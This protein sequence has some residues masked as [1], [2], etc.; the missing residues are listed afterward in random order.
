MAYFFNNLPQSFNIL[1]R[2]TFGNIYAPYMQNVTNSTLKSN[3]KNY[4]YE[5]FN[6]NKINNSTMLTSFSFPKFDYFLPKFDYSLPKYSIYQNNF[7]PIFNN[8]FSVT[9]S[10][11]S[12]SFGNIANKPLSSDLMSWHEIN[13]LSNK[14]SWLDIDKNELKK[15]RNARLKIWNENKKVEKPELNIQKNNTIVKKFNDHLSRFGLQYDDNTGAELANNIYQ[16]SMGNKSCGYCYAFVKMGLCETYKDIDYLPGES[17]IDFS[18][19]FAENKNVKKHFTKIPF[20]IL[21]NLSFNQLPAGCIIHYK[22][23]NNLHK[24]KHG[25]IEIALGNGNAC[26]DYIKS[27]NSGQIPKTA[28]QWEN[29]EVYVPTVLV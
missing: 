19:D 5:Y 14:F 20:D 12:I 24:S 18:A 9:G 15:G 6:G 23:N 17:A 22:Q 25:H 13:N 7:K 29:I 28:Q 26:S 16:G 2:F 8:N 21:Q 1:P 4:N 11:S 3:E 10:S 27:K